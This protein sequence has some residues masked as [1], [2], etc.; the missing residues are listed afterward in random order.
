MYFVWRR[1]FSTVAAYQFRLQVAC[2]CLPPGSR[3][4]RRRRQRL[5]GSRLRNRCDP[6][7]CSRR[8]GGAATAPHL[9]PASSWLRGVSS[10]QRRQLQ[11][12]I[13]LMH[14]SI[15]TPLEGA[16]DA[17]A[18]PNCPVYSA[19][20]GRKRGGRLRLASGEPH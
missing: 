17:D 18:P 10:H 9:P 1:R 13:R 15:S 19:N 8:V 4:P 16:R 7:Q 2:T 11:F 14:C 12:L 5:S 20:C 3:I 6:L